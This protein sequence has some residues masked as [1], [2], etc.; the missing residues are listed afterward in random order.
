[1]LEEAVNQD[2]EIISKKE[3]EISLPLSFKMK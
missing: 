2:S 1:M 3:K